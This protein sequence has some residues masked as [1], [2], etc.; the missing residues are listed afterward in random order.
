MMKR[1]SPNQ[2]VKD[3]TGFLLFARSSKIENALF[4]L[5]L[6]FLPTQLGRHFWPSFSYILGIRTDYL[7]PT[8]YLT[9]ILI[10]LLFIFFIASLKLRPFP[11]IFKKFFWSSSSL[12]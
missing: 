11:S 2:S 10:L 9:D 8:L 12:L 7:S 5:T 4:F 6:L 3:E 1:L